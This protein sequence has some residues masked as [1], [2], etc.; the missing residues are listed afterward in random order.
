MKKKFLSALFLAG[1][2]SL[3]WAQGE[4]CQYNGV[5]AYC[6]W[7]TG[8]FTIN[9]IYANEGIPCATLI[10]DCISDGMLYT[11]VPSSALNTG[12]N[13]G[14]GV[15]CGAAG[16]TWQA[17]NNPNRTSLGCC[18]WDVETQCWDIWSDAED[19]QQQVTDCQG[20]DN[21]YWA[22]KCPNEGTGQ[23]PG[24]TNSIATPSST[25]ANLNVLVQTGSL[26]ISSV[27]EATVQLFDVSGKQMLSEK[28]P[29]GYSV[30]NL[31]GQKVGVYFAVI[32]SGSHKQT[33]KVTLK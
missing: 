32:T 26:H 18:K 12:N 23:C 6:Q 7:G 11:G 22:A 14:E 25:A 3:A 10:A 19:A 17:G 29:S 2:V 13:H 28:V 16:G 9:N 21:Q 31:K 15:N 20:G 1:F 27:R 24:G 5:Q 4:N 33:V 8:C 30:V